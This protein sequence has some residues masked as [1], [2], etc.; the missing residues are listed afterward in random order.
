MIFF[1]L[2]LVLGL[3]ASIPFSTPLAIPS[4][5]SISSDITL[6]YNNDLDVYTATQ[7]KSV[8]LLTPRT[9]SEAETACASL[10]E[11]LL[12]INETFFTTD[13][14]PLLQYQAYEGAYGEGQLYLVASEGDSCAAVNSFGQVSLV[15]CDTELPVL[16]SQSSAYGAY[17]DSTNLLTVYADD[18]T[19][20]GYRDQL[21]FRFEGIPYADAPPRFTYPTGWTGSKTLNAT[22][23]GSECVQAGVPDSSEDCLFLNIWTPFIPE[24]ASTVSADSLKPVLFWIHGGAFT[25]GTGSDPTFEG[26]NVASR[27]DVVLVTINYRLS[28][29]GFLALEDGK[30]NGNFGLADQIAAL[31]WVKEYITAF[32]GDPNRITIFGQS[33]GA[34]S[35]RALLGSPQAIGKYAAAVPMSNLAGSDYATTYSLYYTIPEE[36]TTVVYP[37]LEEIGCNI[38]D[39]LACLTAYNAY[40][41]VNLVNVARFIVVDGTIIT[42]TELPLNGSG[43]V[44][45]V[46]TMM[47]Y[48]RDDGAAFI[49]YPTSTNLT[50][51]LEAQYL[52]ITVANN[53]LFILPTGPNATLDV[54]NVT[55]RAATDVEFRCLDQ[56]TAW[57][58]IQ[59]DLFESIWFY[60]FNRS[61]QTPGFSPNYPVCEAPI[62]ADYPYGDPELEYFKC[63]S[64]E[65][66]YVFASLPS[67]LPYRDQYDLPF[68]QRMLDTWTSFARTYNPNPD[69]AFLTA[70]GYYGT[71]EQLAAESAWLPVTSET[72]NTTPLRTLQWQSFMGAFAEQPQCEYLG[73]PLNYF[74]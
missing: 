19:I 32:G 60:Q 4:P 51:A 27:G 45:S 18:L 53:P 23:F 43:T 67:T 33:A 12:P 34:A 9:Q 64:G 38:T 56:A 65:L 40:D 39:A 71:I 73:Y 6:L 48:M 26:S 17:A 1:T 55:A 30:T 57:S 46:H 22:A 29:L 37:I 70:R 28:T 47:G 15:S 52:P 11:T 10:S 3:L 31:D 49:G 68:M 54:F 41:L 2:V 58:A 69:V 16:C 21:S 72:I 63:H 62:T 59:H 42:H 20:T 14:V 25:S 35:V 8:L 61:Y 66:Y 36:V 74:G 44:A 13:L 24:D 7:H 5:S 50:E